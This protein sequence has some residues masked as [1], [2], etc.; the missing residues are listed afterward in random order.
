MESTIKKIATL[1]LLLI[2]TGTC[3]GMKKN[4]KYNIQF[5][6]KKNEIVATAK[7]KVKTTFGPNFKRTI[8]TTIMK[9]LNDKYYSIQKQTKDEDSSNGV[10]FVT[11][12]STPIDIKKF[13]EKEKDESEIEKSLKLKIAEFEKE[14]N[15]YKKYK[16]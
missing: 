5:I 7:R 9:T 10:T 11:K 14:K 6:E 2:I 1:Q 8:L 3:S 13:C 4:I 15:S 16:K 12:Y